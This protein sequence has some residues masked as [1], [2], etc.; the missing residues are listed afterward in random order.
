MTSDRALIFL[1]ILAACAALQ[2]SIQCRNIVQD[3]KVRPERCDLIDDLFRY[4]MGSRCVLHYDLPPPSPVQVIESRLQFIWSEAAVNVRS[5]VLHKS[6][7]QFFECLS[8]GVL[9]LRLECYNLRSQECRKR[10][11]ELLKGLACDYFGLELNKVGE[12]GNA[13]FFEC[14]EAGRDQARVYR[15]WNAYQ[16]RHEERHD[17]SVDWVDTVRFD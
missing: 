2:V 6:F 1:T 8:S 14:L 13:Y 4:Q 9:S 7:G 5:V 12:C 11:R 3:S 16:D 15:E 17:D 10:C